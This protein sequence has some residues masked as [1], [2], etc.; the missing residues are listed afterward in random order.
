[1][2]AQEIRT[3]IKALKDQLRAYYPYRDYPEVDE[4]MSRIQSQLAQLNRALDRIEAQPTKEV[5]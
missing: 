1:M 3:Q 5:A 4:A 2:D